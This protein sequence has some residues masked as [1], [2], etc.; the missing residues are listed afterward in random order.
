MKQPTQ[1]PINAQHL[2]LL[3]TSDDDIRQAHEIFS[4]DVNAFEERLKD[5]D[6]WSQLVQG[7]LY[8]E[9]V[10]DRLLR[11]ALPNPEE[12]SLRRMG[13]SQRLDLVHALGLLSKPMISVLRSISGLRNR[14]A[15]DLAF[16]ISDEDVANLRNATPKDLIDAVVKQEDRPKRP[17]NLFEILHVVLVNADI[18]R[19][20]LEVQ[21]QLTVKSVVRLRTVL[22]KTPDAHYV[23]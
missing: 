6:R 15:H 19:Q 12:I 5:Q 23:P 17:V 14:T 21:R 8:F 7:H 18:W 20:N 3:A 1:E 10:V 16:E 4:F 11:E 22:E 9:H 2:E 13:F